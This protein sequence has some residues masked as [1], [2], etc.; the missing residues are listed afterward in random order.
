MTYPIGSRSPNRQCLLH[1]KGNPEDTCHD[2]E[3]DDGAA[4]PAVDGTAEVDRHDGGNEGADGEDGADGVETLC[5]LA[6]GDILRWM[7]RREEEEPDGQKKA[8]DDEVDVEGPAPVDFL[9][10]AADDGTE[11][12]A[13]TPYQASVKG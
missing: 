9:E 8:T 1:A 2:E 13:E 7:E 11:D 12:G 6:D 10:G 5:S 4:V 3:R